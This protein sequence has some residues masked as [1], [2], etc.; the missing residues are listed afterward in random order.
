MKSQYNAPKTTSQTGTPTGTVSNGVTSSAS[1]NAQPTG[2]APTGTPTGTAY[3]P[4]DYDKQR[5][6]EYDSYLAAISPNAQE[7]SQIDIA[8]RELQDL[9]QGETFAQAYERMRKEK[10]V[11]DMQGIYNAQAQRATDL[12]SQIQQQAERQYIG[13]TGVTNLSGLINANSRDFARELEHA[14]ATMANTAT[15]INAVNSEIGNVMQYR[16][17]DLENKRKSLQDRIE[18]LQNKIPQAQL[19]I[20]KMK[21]NDSINSISKREANEAAIAQAKLKDKLENGDITSTDRDLRKK[22]VLKAINDMLAPYAKYGVTLR[23][24]SE[25]HAEAILNRMENGQ[26][27]EQAFDEDFSKPFNSS[28]SVLN[29]KAQMGGDQNQWKAQ[30]MTTEDADGNKVQRTVF[31]RT[32]Q[33]GKLE[34]VDQAGNPINA[35]GYAGTGTGTP[36]PYTG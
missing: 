35:G 24:P 8:K 17:Q 18:A 15:A 26:T 28:P 19:D 3:Q 23:V 11:G 27:F 20:L 12:K 10:G 22:A 4:T 16:Q 30:M 6:N 5:S 1:A 25:A 2:N 7:Q 29:A 33:D 36:T 14:T 34:Y 13:S 31:Y 9:S 21:L 32:G